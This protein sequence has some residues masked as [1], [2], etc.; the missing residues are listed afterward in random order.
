VL[1]GA[2]G[3]CDTAAAGTTIIDTSTIGIRDCHDF[4]EKLQE[5]GINYLDCP[6][7]GGTEGAESGALLAMVGGH[8]AVFDDA[9]PI[10]ECFASDIRYVG[11]SGAGTGIKLVIQLIF[12]S[13]LVAFFE[14]VALSDRLGIDIATALSAIK[15]SSANHPT[16]EKRFKNI[17]ADDDSVRFSLKSMLKDLSLAQDALRFAGGEPT[18]TDAAIKSLERAIA[19]GYGEFDAVALRKSN[20]LDGPSATPAKARMAQNAPNVRS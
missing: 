15:N 13:Q 4:A 7:S 10:I 20:G 6:V 2:A 3:L 18:I 9:R 1:F 12:M 19:K 17:L 16:I 11:N 14:G 8:E 5:K